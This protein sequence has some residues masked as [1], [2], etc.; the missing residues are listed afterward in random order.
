MS[1]LMNKKNSFIQYLKGKQMHDG[2]EKE[3]SFSLPFLYAHTVNVRRNL[4]D[5]SF[6]YE[7]HIQITSLSNQ[8]SVE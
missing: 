3:F 8:E 1:L 6:K 2:K 5:K 7:Y 4:K